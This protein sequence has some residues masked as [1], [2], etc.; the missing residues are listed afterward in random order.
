[1]TSGIVTTRRC[2]WDRC[3]FCAL[4][5]SQLSVW[6]LHHPPRVTERLFEPLKHLPSHE[7]SMLDLKRWILPQLLCRPV[8][9]AGVG[10]P[11]T[12]TAQ[13]FITESLRR[14]QRDRRGL[15]TKP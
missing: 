7:E 8:L 2:Q 13:P 3:L 5:A 12:G 4:P 1:M 15:D 10:L 14:L 6:S 9:V 11:E